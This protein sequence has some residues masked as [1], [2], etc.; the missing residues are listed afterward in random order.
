ML[1]IFIFTCGHFAVDVDGIVTGAVS[2]WINPIKTGNERS[3]S[4]EH[5]VATS[6]DTFLNSRNLIWLHSFVLQLSDFPLQLLHF[7]LQFYI[8]PFQFVDFR[9]QQFLKIRLKITIYKFI[10]SREFKLV[11]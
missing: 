10:T 6:V 11:R 8:L 2:V 3:V 9:L 7:H 4:C 1:R 5:L